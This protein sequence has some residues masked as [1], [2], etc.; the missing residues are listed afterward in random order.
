[1]LKTIPTLKPCT[2]AQRLRTYEI[3]RPVHITSCEQADAYI[4]GMLAGRDDVELVGA[5]IMGRDC[6]LRP[7]IQVRVLPAGCQLAGIY[8]PVFAL[9]EE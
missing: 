7:V 2:G 4:A 1:M 6:Q 8:V 9:K 3:E 5:P